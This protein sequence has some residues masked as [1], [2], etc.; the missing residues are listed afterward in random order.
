[1]E[2]RH[3]EKPVTFL[4]TVRKGS[5]C[6][7]KAQKV[8]MTYHAVLQECGIHDVHVEMKQPREDIYV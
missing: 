4:I 7:I 3:L 1:M 6:W 8:V 5:T 2:F